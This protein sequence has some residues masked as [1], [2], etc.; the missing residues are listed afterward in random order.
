MMN[1]YEN[2]CDTVNQRNTFLKPSEFSSQNEK[3]S[4]LKSLSSSARLTKTSHSIAGPTRLE[5]TG[6]FSH[7]FDSA[8]L[9]KLQVVSQSRPRKKTMCNDCNLHSDVCLCCGNTS[10]MSNGVMTDGV[11]ITTIWKPNQQSTQ[12]LKSLHQSIQSSL[13]DKQNTVYSLLSNSF[14]S[15]ALSQFFKKGSGI[16][17]ASLVP[18]VFGTQGRSSGKSHLL[19]KK[20]FDMDHLKKNKLKAK[21]Q[22][23]SVFSKSTKKHSRHKS[24]PN[25][26]VAVKPL[27]H[28]SIT[29][30]VAE[31]KK[32]APEDDFLNLSPLELDDPVMFPLSSSSSDLEQDCLSFSWPSAHFRTGQKDWN[33]K[34]DQNKPTDSNKSKLPDSSKNS[35]KMSPMIGRIKRA[36]LSALPKVDGK[37]VAQNSQTHLAHSKSLASL[38]HLDAPSVEASQAIGI[39]KKNNSR[40]GSISKSWDASSSESSWTPFFADR[41]M[42]NSKWDMLPSRDQCAF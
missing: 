32:C 39:P 19:D 35:P 29:Q 28:F 23:N 34:H 42:G 3:K 8:E 11:S 2:L 20:K 25:R 16:Q 4:L 17:G 41:G 7:S 31:R 37:E 24:D 14:N 21:A 6:N 13:E 36:V 33:E 12:E 15:Q 10:I 1:S 5:T 38:P 40:T 27:E 18:C 9:S 26:I 30:A 22:L